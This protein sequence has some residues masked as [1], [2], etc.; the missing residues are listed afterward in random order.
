[1]TIQ[2]S[3]PKVITSCQPVEQHCCQRQ[4]S[5]NP[6]LLTPC[7][8]GPRPGVPKVRKRGET[9]RPDFECCSLLTEGQRSERKQPVGDEEN[10]GRNQQT[11]DGACRQ[12]LHEANAAQSELFM[13]AASRFKPEHETRGDRHAA[14]QAQDKIEPAQCP[15]L[16][17][18]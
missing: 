1:M 9:E 15:V 11:G 10:D 8:C 18:Q 2:Q 17:M 12:S 4:R 14:D 13:F 16:K 5:K 7:A 3:S 6:A